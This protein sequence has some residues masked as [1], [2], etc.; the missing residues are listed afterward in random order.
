[1]FLDRFKKFGGDHIPNIIEYINE[2]I[3]K[4][5]DVT[6]SIGCDSE[7]K[8]KKTMYAITIMFHNGDLR[9]GAHVVFFRESSD[10]IKDN[11]ERLFKEAQY[12]HDLGIYLDSELQSYTRLD[13]TTL[14]RKKYKYHLLKCE[15]KYSHVPLHQDEVVTN[16]LF[17]SE[18][19]LVD[20]RKVDIH[21][22][23][24]PFEGGTGDNG[25]TKNK[26]YSAY[27]SFVP[28][29]RGLGFRTWAKPLSPASSSA[30]DL[31]LD[32]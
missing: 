17:L 19:D 16:S 7:Q 18:S 13:L 22:D 30:A 24:N 9:K 3:K 10:K 15:G 2:F 20:F 28:W 27:K 1:M 32:E 31:L 5:P 25:F 11:N 12:L 6:I 14:E 29:L 26:S 21:V 8:H 23:F 4:E